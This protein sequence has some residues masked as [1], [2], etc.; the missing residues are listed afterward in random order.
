MSLRVRPLGLVYLTALCL[1]FSWGL[2]IP[3]Y[4]VIL[5]SLGA[6]PIA[7]GLAFTLFNAISASLRLPFGYLADRLGKERFMFWSCLVTGL[8]SAIAVVGIGV[9]LLILAISILGIATA[10]YYQTTYSLVADLT[11]GRRLGR[12]YSILN[13]M[14]QAGWL[15][16]PLVAGFFMEADMLSFLFLAALIS[17]IMASL[18]TKSLQRS[19]STVVQIG[20]EPLSKSLVKALR[21]GW[22]I[23]VS[24]LLCGLAVGF[25]QPSASVF[26]NEVLM[27]S[28]DEVGAIFTIANIAM[29]I[30]QYPGG[31]LID[32]FGGHVLYAFSA[33]ASS[34]PLMFFSQSRVLVEAAF[35]MILY[36]FIT[37]FRWIS[38]DGMLAQHYPQELRTLAMGMTWALWRSGFAVG[39]L[40]CGFVWQGLGIRF[41]FIVSSVLF[42]AAAIIAFKILALRRKAKI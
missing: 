29:L 32:R 41:T 28:Y 35:I 16:A 2:F 5:R 39:S 27:G 34:I 8:A 22:M 9:E 12:A 13:S 31:F 3:L 15:A 37:G 38:G 19:S 23:M 18:A 1:S 7:I 4:P 42:V 36:Y 26:L 17:A 21:M 10:L 20:G 30:A 6:T 24:E 14:S 25:F 11:R 40:T 33:L